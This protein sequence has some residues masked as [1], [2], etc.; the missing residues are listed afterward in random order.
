MT[1]VCGLSARMAATMAC[2][3]G[4]AC[5]TGPTPFPTLP[6]GTI[7]ASRRDL[8]PD[9]AILDLDAEPPKACALRVDAFARAHVVLPLVRGAGEQAA[10]QAPAAERKALVSAP[11]LVGTRG[12]VDTDQKHAQLTGVHAAHLAAPQIIHAADS[13][14]RHGS[15]DHVKALERAQAHMLQRVRRIE[16]FFLVYDAQARSRRHPDAGRRL[17]LLGQ[18]RDGHALA[19]ENE[20][21]DGVAFQKTIHRH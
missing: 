10:L 14:P 6:L 16:N 15:H 18:L 9:G 4:L 21:A 7:C 5:S 1:W 12:A 3:A 20:Q 17:E 2:A 8:D 11:V 13:P 19:R